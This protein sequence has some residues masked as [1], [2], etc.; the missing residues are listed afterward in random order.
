MKHRVQIFV[1]VLF[2]LSFIKSFKYSSNAYDIVFILVCACIYSIYEFLSDSKLKQQVDKLTLDTESKFKVTEKELKE[3]K[4]YV[5]TMSLG[6][7]FQRK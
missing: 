3:T 1:S 5:S 4:N 6:S 7:T 2:L